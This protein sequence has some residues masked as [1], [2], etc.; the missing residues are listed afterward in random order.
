MLYETGALYDESED[1]YVDIQF[2]DMVSS[3]EIFSPV[4]KGFT[5]FN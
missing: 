2:D 5:E 4:I 1:D 3:R